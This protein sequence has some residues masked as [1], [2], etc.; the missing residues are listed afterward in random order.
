M[1]MDIPET[2]LRT[3]Q[4]VDKLF[5]EYL[6]RSTDYTITELMIITSTGSLIEFLVYEESLSGYYILSCLRLFWRFT[7][8]V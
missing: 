5:Q 4:T 2:E 8:P 6:H 7:K 1:P 3:L